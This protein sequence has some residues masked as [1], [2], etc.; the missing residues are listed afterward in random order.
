MNFL[1]RTHYVRKINKALNIKLYKWQIQYIFGKESFMPNYRA[2]GRTTA[3][4]L[5]LCFS[6]GPAMVFQS[7]GIQ[8]SPISGF[9]QTDY[10]VTGL[11]L[12]NVQYGSY[13][14]WC[15]HELE[16]IYHILQSKTKLHL[17]QIEFRR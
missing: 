10:Y 2:S 5:R 13:R 4:I 9:D 8:G 1:K 17:R 6:K 7:R 15:A 12:D 14:V 11:D 16:R 3:H